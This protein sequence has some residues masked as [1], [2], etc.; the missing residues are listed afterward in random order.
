MHRHIRMHPSSVSLSHCWVILMTV[1]TGIAL[2]LPN[3]PE[4]QIQSDTPKLLCDVPIAC[5]WT[6]CH[7][8]IVESWK[9]WWRK[10][11]EEL[12]REF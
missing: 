2:V 9:I 8:G 3:R 6:C 10:E 7:R 4:P 12:Y 1:C 5:S 11:L